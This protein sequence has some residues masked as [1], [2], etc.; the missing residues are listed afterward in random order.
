PGGEWSGRAG[1]LHYAEI[2][3]LVAPPGLALGRLANFINGELL[4]RVVAAPGEP[5]P[6]WAVKF[7]QEVESGHALPLTIEEQTRFDELITP[8]LPRA[9][10]VGWDEAVSIGYAKVVEHI[11]R[12][13]SLGRELA[14]ELA[15]LLAARHP[16]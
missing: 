13:G 10:G 5:A 14:S 3:T 6:W 15:P 11:Q 12:G 4:G 2:M 1:F 9:P 7:P 16:S 8:Y